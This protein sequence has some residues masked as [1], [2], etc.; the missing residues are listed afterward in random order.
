MDDML[1]KYRGSLVGGAG[2]TLWGMPWNFA[3][4][5]KFSAN[6]EKMA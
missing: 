2:V 4:K 1:D 5:D 6:M 3:V